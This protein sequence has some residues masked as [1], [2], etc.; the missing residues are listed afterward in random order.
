[1]A[2]GKALF[3]AGDAAL[4]RFGAMK[5]L[6]APLT[7]PMP[8]VENLIMRTILTALLFGA[9]ALMSLTVPLPAQHAV[10]DSGRVEDSFHYVPPSALQSVKIGD[11][12]FH[13]KDYRGALSRYEEAAKDDPYCAPAYLGLGKVYEKMGKKREALA[14]YHNYLNALPSQKQADEATEAH[15]AIRRLE[16]ELKKG[17]SRSRATKA[18]SAR[19]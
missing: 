15:K 10:P 18:P 3:K 13:R 19:K 14:A 6:P 8:G 1:M 17:N 16:H 7:P 11:F 5:F 9:L 12:Y 2:C 4:A